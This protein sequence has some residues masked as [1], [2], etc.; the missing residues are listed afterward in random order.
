M[1]SWRYCV[2]SRS[3]CDSCS[4]KNMSGEGALLAGAGVGDAACS[5]IAA[6]ARDTAMAANERFFM[7]FRILVTSLAPD[8]RSFN[9]VTKVL[10]CRLC[11]VYRNVLYNRGMQKDLNSRPA[12]RSL[13]WGWFL[14]LMLPGFLCSEPKDDAFFPWVQGTSW[15]YDTLNKKTNEH[16][17]MKVVMEGPW[18]GPESI[19]KLKDQ[20]V[21]VENSSTPGGMIMTQRDTRGK[22][23]QFLLRNE[24]GI[25]ADKLALSKTLTPEIDTRF[26]PA[27]PIVIFPLTP[28]TK[29]HWEGRLKVTGI[30]NKPII[31]DGEVAGWEDLTVPAGHFHC[32]KIHLHEKRGSDIIDEDAW[33]AEG[34]GQVKYDG[35]Q[36]VKELKSY[37]IN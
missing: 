35:G 17:D 30:M 15:V 32:I 8:P 23:R 31:L 13:W 11:P 25:L 12:F 5:R 21:V 22:M 18:G 3:N 6:M 24:K 37:R 7:P 9:D 1:F 4:I 20:G 34:V 27:L 36:Y 28:G 33:Y 10:Q 29:V 19:K 16:F 2:F 14:A 26:T